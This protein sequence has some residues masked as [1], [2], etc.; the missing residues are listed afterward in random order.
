MLESSKNHPTPTLC[1]KKKKIIFHFYE[2]NCLLH[3]TFQ[4]YNCTIK[5][6]T[7]QVNHTEGLR[8]FPYAMV[9]NILN[10]QCVFVLISILVKSTY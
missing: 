6:E 3:C 4:I 8:A 10:I 7:V 9:C 1:L 5:S 2:M